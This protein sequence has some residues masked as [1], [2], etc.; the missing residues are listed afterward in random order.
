MKEI[1]ICFVVVVALIATMQE[2]ANARCDEPFWRGF[3]IA[4]GAC[5]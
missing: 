5:R 3:G 2:F 4:F 1:A